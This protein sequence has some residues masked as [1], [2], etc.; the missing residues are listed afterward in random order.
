M[1]KEQIKALFEKNVEY[2]KRNIPEDEIYEFAEQTFMAAVYFIYRWNDWVDINEECLKDEIAK[3]WVTN[4]MA[5]L[6][7]KEKNIDID[8]DLD[9]DLK[10]VEE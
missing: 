6:R 9:L 7:C 10:S 8:L 5:L 2:L 3:K 1:D 4:I